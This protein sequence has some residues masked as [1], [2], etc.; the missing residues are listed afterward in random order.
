MTRRRSAR[1][2]ELLK[3][4]V[5]EAGAAVEA[6]E[7]NTVVAARRFDTD[8]PAG[9]LDVAFFRRACDSRNCTISASMRQNTQTNS[10]GK[11]TGLEPG[12]PSSRGKNKW[13]TGVH[14]RARAGTFFPQVAGS[15]VPNVSARTR[16]CPSWRTRFVPGRTTR[17]HTRGRVVKTLRKGLFQSTEGCR[18]CERVAWVNAEA[19]F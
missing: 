15:T 7:G 10:R 11:L 9:N 13:G 8:A 17:S 18:S 14:S 2:F 3:V 1:A 16:P 4:I 6:E 19:Q 5:W 12:T